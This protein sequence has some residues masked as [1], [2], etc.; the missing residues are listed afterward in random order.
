VASVPL[1][2]SD[3]KLYAANGT[4][5]ANL[6]TMVL[7]YQLEGRTLQTEL[8]VS[9]EIDELIFGYDWLVAHECRWHFKE[10]MVFVHERPVSL[11]TRHSRA[12]VRRIYV[13]EA[14][15]IAPGTEVNVPVSLPYTTLHSP[16]CDW[17]VDT[18]TIGPGVFA[19]RT[20]LPSEDRFAAI[21]LI[22]VSGQPYAV[23]AGRCMGD[24]NRAECLWAA[25][26]RPPL[27]NT[28]EPL[29]WRST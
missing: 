8:V 6:G 4:E 22:N 28:S 11:R 13:R 5:I 24:A 29:F 1:A 12:N 26:P 18:K 15:T 17:V 23:R 9:D 25:P 2:K 7:R 16:K 10:R 20:L 21:R 19:A 14:V 3:I 27:G